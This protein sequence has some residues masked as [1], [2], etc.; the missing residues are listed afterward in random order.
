VFAAGA[1]KRPT[2]YDTEELKVAGTFT[3]QP[4][5]VF[6]SAFTPDGKS[7]AVAGSGDEVR[8]Y[9]AQTRQRSGTFTGHQEWVYALA[10]R[11]DGERLAVAGYEGMVRIYRVSDE[12]EVRSFV[13]VPLG[14]EW[15]SF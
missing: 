11:P 8:V 3:V 10:F 4:G 2:L 5:E 6:V 1:F 14:E 13:P 15:H 9:T 7:I 12:K